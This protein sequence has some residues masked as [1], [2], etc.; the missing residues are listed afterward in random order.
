[1]INR[2]QVA[3]CILGT[4]IA[5]AM[6]LPYEG[7]SRRRAPKLLGPPDRFRFLMRRG[8]VSDD[9]E[10]TCMVAQALI[11]SDFDVQ[12]FPHQFAKRLRWWFASIPAGI[13]KATA[14]ACIK[15]WFGYK[16]TNSGVFSAG[17][18]PA[19]RSAIFGAVFDD[20]DTM[21]E[22]VRVAARISHTDPKAEF[23]AIA[24]ALAALHN[25]RHETID[26]QEFINQLSAI[27]GSKGDEFLLLMNAVA[28]SVAEG[29][30]TLDFAAKNGMAKGV[31][32]YT[33]HT[34]PIVIHAWLCHP[35]NYKSAVMTVI[36]CGGDADTT[37]AIVGGI[38]GAGAGDSGIPDDWISGLR[39]WPASVN[40][41]EQL[42]HQ[43]TE[44]ANGLKNQQPLTTNFFWTVLR[45]V[46]FLVVVL[47]HG[48]R[49]LLPPY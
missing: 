8:M 33:Y 1:M 16:P 40:W 12:R 24:V 20:V 19:M 28:A 15:L 38:V 14:R 36:E 21:V 32:G 46:L 5:D 17:N 37:A 23:G 45:N 13:G 11:A 49:R 29:E 2:S 10:H 42:S 18:G 34:V 7:V 30:S 48:L 39:E 9:T 44:T 27:I 4:A 47:K 41:M 3:G 26:A 6:G 22:F 43:L 25:R 35:R 31:S